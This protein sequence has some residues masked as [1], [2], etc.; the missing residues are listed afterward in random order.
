MAAQ[1]GY[2]AALPTCP[3][4]RCVLEGH[5]QQCYVR[6][7]VPVIYVNAMFSNCDGHL[8]QAKDRLQLITQKRV[9]HPPHTC[10]PWTRDSLKGRPSKESSQTA[11]DTYTTGKTF[12]KTT[13]AS[14]KYSYRIRWSNSS[15]VYF[16]N[17]AC[18]N[19]KD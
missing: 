9:R 16:T 11:L 8:S 5:R 7:P 12:G 18:D 6:M 4:T 17:V 1:T 3:E 10:L 14:A 2:P 19:A 15:V 13:L